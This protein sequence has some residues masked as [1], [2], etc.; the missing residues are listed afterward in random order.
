MEISKKL[1]HFVYIKLFPEAAWTDLISTQPKNEGCKMLPVNPFW[2]YITRKGYCI[3]SNLAMMPKLCELKSNKAC[4]SYA[5]RYKG[6]FHPLVWQ[7]A[8]NSVYL[9]I[10]FIVSCY[11]EEATLKLKE[12]M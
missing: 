6:E 5:Y 4:S 7:K 3:Y 11:A 2:K 9:C 1:Q 8:Q 10:M 12:V